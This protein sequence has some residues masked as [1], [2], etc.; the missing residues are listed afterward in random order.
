MLRSLRRWRF[1]G[2]LLSVIWMAGVALYGLHGLADDD[3]HQRMSCSR[4]RAE[5]RASQ[6]CAADSAA[7]ADPFC[8]FND[9]DCEHSFVKPSDLA[10]IADVAIVPPIVVWVC[11]CIFSRRRKATA[12]P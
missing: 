7:S 4:F 5:A 11:A 3:H 9:A 12:S 8:R 10:P 6:R 2:V 1:I